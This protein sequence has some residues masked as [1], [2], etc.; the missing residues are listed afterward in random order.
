VSAS[1]AGRATPGPTS[2]V[3]AKSKVRVAAGAS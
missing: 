1:L 3:E 2:S